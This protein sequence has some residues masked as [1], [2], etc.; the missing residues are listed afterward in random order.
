MS[1]R[2]ITYPLPV[3]PFC[4]ESSLPWWIETLRTPS[5]TLSSVKLFWSG[6]WSQLEKANKGPHKTGER[7]RIKQ[8]ALLA[9]RTVCWDRWQEREAPR[10]MF[11]LV[12]IRK[13]S[14]LKLWAAA[15]LARV[16]ICPSHIWQTSEIYVKPSFKISS[17]V[18]ISFQYCD[19][20]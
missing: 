1:L 7:G 17:E 5:R 9:H 16:L 12:L 2:A 15:R 8:H 20:S 10:N 14:S 4:S 3:S 11:A 19:C 6:V 13:V 18:G